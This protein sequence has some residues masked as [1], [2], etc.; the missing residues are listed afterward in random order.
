[1]KWCLALLLPLSL[2]AVLSGIPKYEV[3][4]VDGAAHRVARA[5]LCL[6]GLVLAIGYTVLLICEPPTD[7]EAFAIFTGGLLTVVYP[8]WRL[9]Q[10]G[11]DRPY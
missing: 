11:T 4:H 1:M 2:I 9:H 10:W 6:Y 5:G 8:A 7:F 3:D